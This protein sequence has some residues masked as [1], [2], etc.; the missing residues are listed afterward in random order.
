MYKHTRYIGSLFREC[1][2]L[3]LLGAWV[4]VCRLEG[5]DGKVQDFVSFEGPER[6]PCLSHQGTGCSWD[7]PLSVERWGWVFLCVD[8]HTSTHH[9]VHSLTSYTETHTIV[10]ISF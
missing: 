6:D 3:T 2:T 9:D 7:H 1:K 5:E 4:W 8:S 10:E